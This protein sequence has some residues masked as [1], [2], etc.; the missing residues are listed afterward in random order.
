M[1]MMNPKQKKKK[2]L[3]NWLWDVDHQTAAKEKIDSR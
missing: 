3:P 1:G 2:I